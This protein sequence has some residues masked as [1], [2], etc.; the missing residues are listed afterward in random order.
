MSTDGDGKI[1]LFG[2]P[3]DDA[4]PVPLAPHGRG[5]SIAV[6]RPGLRGPSPPAPP[7]DADGKDPSATIAHWTARG[8]VPRRTASP[9]RAPATS[10][11]SGFPPAP[12]ALLFALLWNFYAVR[13]LQPLQQYA[14]HLPPPLTRSVATALFIHPWPTQECSSPLAETQEMQEKLTAKWASTRRRRSVPARR[15]SPR[16]RPGRVDRHDSPTAAPP[17]GC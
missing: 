4:L 8:D 5:G 2:K 10:P 11:A 15:P 14:P 16:S 6:A 12:T 3:A 17:T 9:S 1:N 13:L 7:G